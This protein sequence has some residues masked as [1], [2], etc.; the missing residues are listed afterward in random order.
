MLSIHKVNFERSD[1]VDSDIVVAHDLYETGLKYRNPAF[2]VMRTPY[3]RFHG[4]VK[5]AM[6]WWVSNG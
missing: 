5:R 4:V 3:N 2:H 1:L 6:R